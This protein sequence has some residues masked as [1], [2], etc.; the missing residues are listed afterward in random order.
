MPYTTEQDSKKRIHTDSSNVS[1]K[2]LIQGQPAVVLSYGYR[3]TADQWWMLKVA[4]DAK[5]SFSHGTSG[6][7]TGSIGATKTFADLFDL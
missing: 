2:A 4:K 6:R 7:G 1:R 5:C 3:E